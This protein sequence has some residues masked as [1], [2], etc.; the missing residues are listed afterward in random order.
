[1]DIRNTLTRAEAVAVISRV[2]NPSLRNPI[3]I[4][5]RDENGIIDANDLDKV[6]IEETDYKVLKDYFTTDLKGNVV[7]KIGNVFK[8]DT[9][10]FPVRYGNIVITGIEKLNSGDTLSRFK[11]GQGHD[12]GMYQ[13]RIVIHAYAISENDYMFGQKFEGYY[14]LFPSFNVIVLH[15]SG[16]ASINGING[17]KETE[18]LFD[19]TRY[20]ELEDTIEKVELN[21]SFTAIISLSGEK[22][23]DIDGLMI[24][25]KRNVINDLLEI[26]T[27]YIKTMDV[28]NI[29]LP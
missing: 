23:E 14:K 11:N 12:A 13:E 20:T 4:V 2:I 28:N 8:A 3:K 26:D 19:Q 1:V 22:L 25:E 27:K 5:A 7:S 16:E 29:K 18:V 21:K 10:M 17:V 6:P 9:L 15:N 24:M